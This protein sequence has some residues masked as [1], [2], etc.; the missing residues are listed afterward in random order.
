M[1]KRMNDNFLDECK[2]INKFLESLNI[3]N[4]FNDDKIF[5]EE[6]R[7]QLNLSNI[8][9]TTDNLKSN[10]LSM[11]CNIDRINNN[12]QNMCDKVKA[13]P[14]SFTKKDFSRF[15]QRTVDREMNS[16]GNGGTNSLNDNFG[17]WML[18][19]LYVCLYVY[20]VLILLILCI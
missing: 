16:S 2:D 8:K 5:N 18:F 15:I 1:V 10:L 6:F 7:S 17:D 3:D 11:N 9:K 19:R 13:N 12:V 14:S 4:V 20:V